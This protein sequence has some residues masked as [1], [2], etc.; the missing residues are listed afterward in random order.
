MLSKMTE[1]QRE[2][3]IRKHV[4]EEVHT[5]LSV[6]NA[7]TSKPKL[8]EIL[9]EARTVSESQQSKHT[10]AVGL[11]ALPVYNKQEQVNMTLNSIICCFIV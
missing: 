4:P 1:I 11:V 6:E 10:V 2:A 5:K 7:L 9:G 8:P 3:L